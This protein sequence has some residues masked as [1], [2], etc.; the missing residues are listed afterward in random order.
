MVGGRDSG[1]LAAMGKASLLAATDGGSDDGMLLG[2]ELS[3]FNVQAA[4]GGYVRDG[5]SNK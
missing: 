5:M 4:V 2:R 3:T 1:K